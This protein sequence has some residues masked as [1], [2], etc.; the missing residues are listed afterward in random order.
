MGPGPFT[1]FAPPNAAF[2]AL[3]T[4]TPGTIAALLADAARLT[5]VLTFHVA[6]GRV[7]S[8]DLHSGM[9]ITTVEGKVLTVRIRSSD[10]RVTIIGPKQR[11]VR[12]ARAHVAQADVMASNGVIH[13][14]DAVLVPPP[15]SAGGGGH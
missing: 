7:L 2:T 1:V 3:D 12:Q 13:V 8:T 6:S 15:L 5:D 11:G 10:N 9:R 14:I 4:A